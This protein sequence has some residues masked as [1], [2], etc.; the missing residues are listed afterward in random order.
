MKLPQ[1]LS[2]HAGFWLVLLLSVFAWAPATYPGYWQALEGFIPVFN[3]S[4]PSP[5]ANIAVQ[6]DLWRGMGSGTFLLARPFLVLGFTPTAAVR[7]SFVL[8]LILGGLG[9]YSWLQSY[10]GDR[11]A[12]VAGLIYLFAPPLL[13]TVYVRGSLSD[14]VVVMLLPLALAG[15]AT[16]RRT[17]A[18]SAAAIVVIAI[19]WMWQA[20]AGLAVWA[21]ILLIGYTIIVERNWIAT[22]IVFVSS[23]AALTSLASLLDVTA[24]PPVHFTDHFVYLFQLFQHDWQTAPSTAGWQDTYPFQLGLPALLFT[25]F[26][27]ASFIEQ[28]GRLWWNRVQQSATPQEAPLLTPMS[29]PV[30][31]RLWLFSIISIFVLV[32][33]TLPLSQPLWAWSGAGRLLTYPWQLLLLSVPLWAV[34]AGALP[35]YHRLFRQTPTWVVVALLIVLNSYGYLSADFTQVTPPTTPIALFGE[36]SEIVVLDVALTENRQPRSTELTVTWQVLHPLAV[37]YNIF[38]QALRGDEQALTVSRQMDRQPLGPEQPPTRWQPGQIYQATY[39][40]D[41]EG[42]PADALLTY[43]FGYYDWHDGT[44][45]PVNWGIDDKLIFY[46]Q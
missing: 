10:L 26:A 29:D 16:Y 4:R 19:L 39:T 12:G 45:L 13:A 18:L 32:L 31:V 2:Y 22:L 3:A 44:R 21:T 37:D 40:L 23:A 17:R 24:P 11:A 34:T 1:R 15:L 5:L 38:F 20:Q 46:G 42:I 28:R 43:Y 25:L 27:M 30:V 7:V 36:Q 6:P 41:L 33:L 9:C 14:T 8:A 35:A